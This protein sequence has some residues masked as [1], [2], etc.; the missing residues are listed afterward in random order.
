MRKFRVS[1]RNKRTYTGMIRVVEAPDADTAASNLIRARA[2][3]S[4]WERVSCREWHRD[5]IHT[6]SGFVQVNA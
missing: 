2:I 6:N 5:P 3:P 1:L 4:E